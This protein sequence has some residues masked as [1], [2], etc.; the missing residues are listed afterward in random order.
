MRSL[1]SDPNLGT[2][3][4]GPKTQNIGVMPD[5]RKIINSNK[6]N[7]MLQVAAPVVAPHR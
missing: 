3:Y 4:S 5:L 7:A 6:L 1:L 2:P